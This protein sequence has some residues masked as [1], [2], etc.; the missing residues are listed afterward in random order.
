MRNATLLIILLLLAGC[1]TTPQQP[2][3]ESTENQTAVNDTAWVDS[4][5][6]GYP[7]DWLTRDGA[8][9]YV[10]DGDKGAWALLL[11]G[12][13]VQLD[14]KQEINLTLHTVAKNGDT[15]VIVNDEPQLLWEGKEAFYL[16]ETI[17]VYMDGLKNID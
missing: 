9:L 12:Q 1:A 3:N 5:G 15:L 14:F 17:L 16:N 7:D 13:T 8:R 4:D 11:V 2:V 10:T 6:D